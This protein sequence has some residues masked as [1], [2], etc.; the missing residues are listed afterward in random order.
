MEQPQHDLDQ[1]GLLDTTMVAVMSEM[2]RTPKINNQ[3]E[4]LLRQ[5][6]SGDIDLRKEL[7]MGFN[8]LNENGT[9]F[10]SKSFAPEWIVD[11]N[12]IG[13]LISAFRSFSGEIFSENFDR[14]KF[15]EYYILVRTESPLLFCYIYK[16]QS[17]N[18]IRRIDEFL[19]KIKENKSVWDKLLN[20]IKFNEVFSNISFPGFNEILTEVFPI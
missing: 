18:A 12:L 14:A 3:M 1:R 8:I 9:V 19:K 20:F 4:R 7:P 5:G 11:E 13:A 17:Y 15:G 10:F 6:E 16:G 2:G